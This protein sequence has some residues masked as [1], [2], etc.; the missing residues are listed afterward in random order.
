[1]YICTYLLPFMVASEGKDVIHV[2]CSKGVGTR[3]LDQRAGSASV[4][5]NY[6]Y[7]Y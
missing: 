4:Q 5:M 6:C 2:A 7:Y 3:V 1:M